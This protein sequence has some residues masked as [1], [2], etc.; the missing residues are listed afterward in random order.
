MYL[1]VSFDADLTGLRAAANDSFKYCD[2]VK[3]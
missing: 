3:C 2:N 1:A